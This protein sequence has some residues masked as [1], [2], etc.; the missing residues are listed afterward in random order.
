MIGKAIELNGQWLVR[1]QD[2][3][4]G[5]N[6]VEYIDEFIPIHSFG[7]VTNVDT[8]RDKEIGFGIVGG[9]AHIISGVIPP[10]ETM[11]VMTEK[12]FKRAITD[13]FLAGVNN[14][15]DMLVDEY[16]YQVH[17]KK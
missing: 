9:V 12:E 4:R 17:T 10:P 11:K 13:A 5:D 1:Y 3:Y 16:Y 2:I 8:I 7:L 6:R 15:S 14:S